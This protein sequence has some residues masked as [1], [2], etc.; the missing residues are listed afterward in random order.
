MCACKGFQLVWSCLKT[1]GKVQ[2]RLKRAFL[3]ATNQLILL[4]IPQNHNQANLAGFWAVCN[5][6]RVP[7][8]RTFY[9]QV[10]A[11]G[12][13]VFSHFKIHF[14]VLNLSLLIDDFHREKALVVSMRDMA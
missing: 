7:S 11:F 2:A 5:T 12:F 14:V 9:S 13:T 3:L 4:H 8:I 1:Q 6:A 10:K